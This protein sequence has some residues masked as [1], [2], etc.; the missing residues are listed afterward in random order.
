MKLFIAEK[1]S[2]G[3]AIAETLPK[4]IQSKEGYILCGDGSHVSWCIGHLL[5]LAEPHEYEQHYKYWN[6]EHL[7][8]V[9]EKWKLKAK[10]KTS[11]QL[12]ILKALSKKATEVIHAGDPDR[13]GQLLVDQ[14]IHHLRLDKLPTFR[15]LI[16]DLNPSAVTQALQS[17]KPNHQ[18]KSL[19]ISALARSRAD[20]L[21]GINMTR[22]Y[23]LQGRKVN[24]QGV[25]SVGR[26]QTPLLGL[27]VRRDLEIEAF[28]SKPFY[29]VYAHVFESQESIVE[30]AQGQVK[31]KWVP[32]EACSPYCDDEKRVLSKALAENVVKRI[33]KQSAEVMQVKKKDKSI[34][35]PLP[36]NLS[37]LQIDA[38]ILFQ[39][40]AQEVLDICQE[41]YEKYKLITYPRSDNRFLPEE[42]YSQRQ[43]VLNAITGNLPEYRSAVQKADSRLRSKAWN[44][45]KVE[46]HHGIIPTQKKISSGLP[47]S[48]KNVYQLICRQ[49]LYQF[50][51]P[52]RFK[53]TVID[54]KIAGGLFV[55]KGLM[56][57]EMGW[58]NIAKLD[59]QSGQLI[60][61][62]VGDKPLPDLKK[63]QVLFCSHG[64]LIEKHTQPPQH[65]TD[66][67][68]LSA[69][70]GIARFVK[71][72]EVR[73]I[74]RETDGLG[75]EA[76]RA[77]IIEL[78]FKRGF[79]QRQ[80]KK[81]LS[82]ETGRALVACLPDI[83]TVPD[84]TAMWESSLMEISERK[85][86]YEDFMNPLIVTL[87]KLIGD[88]Q[89]VVP[90]GLKNVPQ[91]TSNFR[92]TYQGRKRK[93]KRKT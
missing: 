8:I 50:Y 15:C 71:D 18:F 90:A 2:L 39:L 33:E 66:A 32:S 17:L 41:L 14:V 58:K 37:A 52:H 45:K 11:K 4:P 85:S 81:I 44:D 30:G 91:S 51:P 19:S 47:L 79:L 27:V 57:Q 73:K 20:W 67:T 31:A 43:V 16:N 86:K 61:L 3:R 69:M 40:K 93:N 80:G 25:L 9:P 83:A 62:E 76:T 38:A 13:E 65:F 75:T 87:Q 1:P 34:S 60:P 92:K 63:G 77:G 35:S 46:A 88:S 29:E 24:Y 23:T 6:V 42:H 48:L 64:E 56:V 72:P 12:K 28:V 21:Y 84:M 78:L 5:E 10:P 49:Y 89:S 36:Y 53:D 54:F 74:L 59:K 7:P 55:T 68:L 70:T 22:A 82:T 26:V